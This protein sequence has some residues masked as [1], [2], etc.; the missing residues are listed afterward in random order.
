[1]K[2][3]TLDEIN[4]EF[5]QENLVFEEEPKPP[6]Q[7]P[8][9]PE[10]VTQDYNAAFYKEETDIWKEAEPPVPEPVPQGYNASIYEEEA[11]VWEE[12]EPPVRI[13]ARPDVSI[14]T[15]EQLRAFSR[16]HLLMMIR[17]LEKELLQ[18]KR[19]RDSLLIAYEAGFMNRKKRR[20]S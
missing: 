10:Q 3:K 20:T 4:L 17:D 18:A 5:I 15:D 6:A 13:Q 2:M 1:M 7:N 14:I 16:K 12:P 19:E 9:V 8:P 11:G